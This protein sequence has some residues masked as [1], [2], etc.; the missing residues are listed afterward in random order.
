MANHPDR[1][2]PAPLYRVEQGMAH[3]DQIGWRYWEDYRDHTAALAEARRL[4][5]A[6]VL[7]LRQIAEFRNGRRWPPA[8]PKS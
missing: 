7:E 8:P 3:A 2:R 6:R 1:A 4:G 5:F